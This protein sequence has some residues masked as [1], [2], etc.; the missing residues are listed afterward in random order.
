[1]PEVSR[2]ARPGWGLRPVREVLRGVEEKGGVGMIDDV[3]STNIEIFNRVHVANTNTEVRAS[4]QPYRGI[5][6]GQCPRCRR[7]YSPS[8]LECPYCCLDFDAV[9]SK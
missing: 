2:Q 8:A 6:G 5:Q 3:T 7:T 1:M 4:V 9:R